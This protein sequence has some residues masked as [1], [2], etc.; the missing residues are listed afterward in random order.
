[1]ASAPTLD[2]N[3]LGDAAWAAAPPATGF[4]QTTPY[5][6][7]PASEETEVRLVYTA[8]SLFV[9]VVCRDREPDRIIVSDTGRDGSLEDTDSFQLVLDTYRDRQTGFLFGTNPA[10]IEYDGQ[11]VND[12]QGDA[13]FNLN[14][15]GAWQVRTRVGE[16]GWSAEFAIPFRTLRYAAGASEWGVNFMRGI[17]RHK[18][19]AYWAPLGRQEGI[20]RVSRAGALKGLAPP[21]RRSLQVTPYALGELA[22]DFARDREPRA[23]GELGGD[24]KWAVTPSLALDL[25]LNTDFAQVEVDEQQVNLDRFNLFFP[26]KRPF[27]LENAGTFAVGSPGL[28][29][30]FFSRRIGLGPQGEVVPILAGARLSGKAGPWTI[31]ALD[32]Q[33]RSLPGV[34]PAS[35][36]AVARLFRELP[37]RSGFGAMAV[38]RETTS[39]GGGAGDHN[40][41]FA[42]DGRWGLGR[43]GRLE[44]FLAKTSTP[45]RP[46]SDV[47]FQ[48]AAVHS[49]PAWDFEASYTDVGSRFNPEA[50]FLAREGGYRNPNLLAFRRYRPE[51]FL[52]LHELRPHVRWE[53]YWNRSGFQQTGFLHV[54]NH[55]EWRSGHE[56]HTGVNVTRQG[57]EAPFEIYPGVRVP[58]GSYDHEE[59][60]LVAITDQARAVSFDGRLIVGGFFGGHR[61]SL[62]P[63]LRARLGAKL[64]GEL[65]WDRNDIELPGGSFVT[66][67]LRLRASYAFTTKL[68]AQALVQYNDRADVW[69]TNLRVGWLQTANAG[70]FL[71]YNETRDLDGVPLPVRNRSL[72]VKL[73][74]FHELLD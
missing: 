17:R 34:A 53:G 43:H 68:F 69:S 18:E 21:R 10:G 24:L 54:D 14:W 71:V 44:G 73:S 45:G 16:Y 26:E 63:S 4:R 28:V 11:V 50:G 74:R 9:G 47:A 56:I 5:E 15:D 41:A 13:G 51:R 32:M 27:F 25:T 61:L 1:V 30:L 65:Y 40:R 52:G 12:G 20:L 39:A 35:N 19:S 72:I 62:R 55:W 37:N 46:G 67:L 6:G 8:E 3:V 48:L 33:T 31:G 64:T 38:N 59:L 36:F 7:R 60:Q 57:V 49:S 42:L 58:V 70:L 23:S 66:D 22:R 29:E 2:G